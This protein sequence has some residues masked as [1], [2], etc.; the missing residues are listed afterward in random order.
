MLPANM[1]TQG[2]DLPSY[3]KQQQRPSERNF[4][5]QNTELKATRPVIPERQKANEMSLLLPLAY[6]L[7]S[8]QIIIW[9]GDTGAEPRETKV[10]RV[11]RTKCRGEESCTERE[12]QRSAEDPHK[13]SAEHWSRHECDEGPGVGERNYLKCQRDSVQHNPGLG[14]R[15]APTGQNKNLII[16]NH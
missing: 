9:G 1:E 11:S 6:F 14:I 10:I 16:P 8:F 15:P 5:F 12:P 13:H 4:D 2:P 7:E 3:L